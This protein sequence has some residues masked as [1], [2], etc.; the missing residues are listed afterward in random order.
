MEMLKVRTL[1]QIICAW[2]SIGFAAPLLAQ[3]ANTKTT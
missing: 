1:A 2:M 3:T